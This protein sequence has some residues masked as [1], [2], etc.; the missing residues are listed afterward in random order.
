MGE[1]RRRKLAQ[2]NTEA[3]TGQALMEPPTGWPL[4][5]PKEQ[6]RLEA[7]FA[8]LGIEFSRPVFQD[9]PAFLAVERRRPEILDDYAR[10]VEV[11][12]Y[13]EAELQAAKRKIEVAAGVVS[14]AVKADGRH[15]LCVTA[16]GV[17]S[18]M[19]DEMGVW[20][21]LVKGTMTVTF[22]PAVSGGKQFFY[23]L[24]AGSFE[25]PHAFVVAP[26][27][28]VVDAT[29]SAQSYP[30]DSMRA[31]LPPLILQRDFIP[32]RWKD[33][34]IASPLVRVSQLAGISLKRYLQTRNPHMLKRMDEFPARLA[35]YPGG[36]CA[37]VVAGIGGYSEKLADLTSVH[38]MLAG[39]TPFA[40]FESQVL[41]QL[42]SSLQ[43]T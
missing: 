16:S 39:K 33:E 42:A 9:S 21:F 27:F 10:Y 11:R 1:A 30:S 14:A 32:Y 43:G 5:N 17:L 24:D 28:L 12:A 20:N 3:S 23:A 40:L 2:G 26:P 18:R 8:D 34:D 38:T 6:A 31:A 35:V 25:A 15:G 36:S 37:Y 29:A 22:P 19:L 4:S 41:P 13:S 7:Q